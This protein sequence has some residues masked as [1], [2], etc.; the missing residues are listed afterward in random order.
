MIVTHGTDTMAYTSAAV[1]F[2]AAEP[3]QAGRLFTGSQIPLSSPLSDGRANL[4]TAF[5]AVEHM[6]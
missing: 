2:Y 1:T 4:A 5:A 3:A 6:V